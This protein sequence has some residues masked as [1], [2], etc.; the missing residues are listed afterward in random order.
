MAGLGAEASRFWKFLEPQALQ[1]KG[2]P[3]GAK[4]VVRGAQGAQ[5][6]L[7]VR[8]L[9]SG[10][11]QGSRRLDPTGRQ[12][13]VWG[14]QS[15]SRTASPG[16][17]PSGGGCTEGAGGPTRERA[18]PLN[19]AGLPRPNGCALAREPGVGR[20]PWR[21]RALRCAAVRAAREPV[22]KRA[23]RRRGLLRAAAG[24]RPGRR[25]TR[26]A[27][28]RTAA[29]FPSPSAPGRRGRW[30]EL[31]SGERLRLL[32]PAEPSEAESPVPA[33]GRR[34]E[35]QAGRG[36]WRIPGHV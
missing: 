22:R 5:A 36:F 27:G 3:P 30:S 19:R 9:I 4:G 13:C 35:G 18:D 16:L 32:G 31:A 1:L 11:S 15:A 2:A 33:G 34:A 21:P 28:P 20:L 10:V 7:C 29:G 23:L 26:G 24:I 17:T 8:R 14:G 12:R 6:A 25:V